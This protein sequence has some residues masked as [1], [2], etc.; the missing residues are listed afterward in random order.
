MTSSPYD[1]VGMKL[2]MRWRSKQMTLNLRFQTQS[3]SWRMAVDGKSGGDDENV[4]SGAVDAYA[5]SYCSGHGV[6]A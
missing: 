6:W 2:M 4:R 1:D 5:A 3:Q